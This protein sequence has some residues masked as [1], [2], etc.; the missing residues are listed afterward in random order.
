VADL[1]CAL[2]FLMLFFLFYRY[3]VCSEYLKIKI[4]PPH[5]FQRALI[6]VL[7]SVCNTCSH[8]SLIYMHKSHSDSLPRQ[9][10]GYHLL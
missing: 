3:D 6:M 10:W 8:Q 5:L 2:L 4:S 9:T 1:A 7:I